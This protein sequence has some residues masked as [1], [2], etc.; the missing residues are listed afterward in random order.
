MIGAFSL[1]ERMARE[2]E[3]FKACVKDRIKNEHSS[4]AVSDCGRLSSDD[5]GMY[6]GE[7]LV[8]GDVDGNKYTIKVQTW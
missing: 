2:T 6:L 1:S 8:D 5:G 3:K 4:S 7:V